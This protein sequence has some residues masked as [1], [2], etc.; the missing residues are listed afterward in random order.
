MLITLLQWDCATEYT[1][2]T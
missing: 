2:E 1:Q